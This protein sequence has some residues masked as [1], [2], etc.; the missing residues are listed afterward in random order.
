MN[1]IVLAFLRTQQH[2]HYL[3][4]VLHVL[5]AQVRHR[6]LPVCAPGDTVRDTGGVINY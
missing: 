4:L 3:E 6:R 1:I 5:A 2:A